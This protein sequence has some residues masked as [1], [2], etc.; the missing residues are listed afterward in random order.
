MANI[1]VKWSDWDNKQVNSLHD[2]LL[3]NYF[4]ISCYYYYSRQLKLLR[5]LATLAGCK[6]ELT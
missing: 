1:G 5:D 3:P 6:A 4:V 2:G